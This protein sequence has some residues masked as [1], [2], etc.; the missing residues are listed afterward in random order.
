MRE[1]RVYEFDVTREWFVKAAPFLK[2]LAGT[3]SLMLPVAASATKL[4]LDEVASKNLE[5]QLD[6]GK[7]CAEVM[8][9][10]SEMITERLAEKD[11][12]ES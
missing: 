1:E 9:G 2:I 5:N 6:F 12:P 8:L 4:T 3:L 10:A 7:E 11:G